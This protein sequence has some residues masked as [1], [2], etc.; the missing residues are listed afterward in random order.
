MSTVENQFLISLAGTTEAVTTSPIATPASCF[1]SSSTSRKYFR[2]RET[3]NPSNEI[4]L[5]IA[6]TRWPLRP[7]QS[8]T[9][10]IPPGCRW[11][12][13]NLH[14]IFLMTRLQ[15]SFESFLLHDSLRLRSMR[16]SGTSHMIATSTY[17]PK[18]SHHFSSA[19]GIPTM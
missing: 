14:G 3:M 11:I 6:N 18:P 7:R 10:E 2:C 8:R 13:R 12:K 5:R 1:T 9:G 16:R 4:L 19:N 17:K 15:L